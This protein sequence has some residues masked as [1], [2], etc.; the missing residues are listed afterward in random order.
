MR[1]NKRT[2]E[3]AYI[4]RMIRNAINWHGV[5]KGMPNFWT[6]DNYKG[7]RAVEKKAVIV[8][9]YPYYTKSSRAIED[10]AKKI[11]EKI[12]NDK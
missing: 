8:G 2:K 11:Y 10:I 7:S 5:D 4:R 3:L 1:V 6:T 9:N 12:K